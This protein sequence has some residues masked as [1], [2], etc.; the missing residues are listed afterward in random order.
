MGVLKERLST[1][2][3]KHGRESTDLMSRVDAFAKQ[4]KN[5]KKS[6]GQ[7]S[8]HINST[9]KVYFGKNPDQVLAN[10]SASLMKF[11][12]PSSENLYNKVKV[13]P[14]KTYPGQM[15][16]L[17]QSSLPVKVNYKAIDAELE[18]DWYQKPMK[19]KHPIASK[20]S[21]KSTNTKAEETNLTKKPQI[22][23]KLAP[24]KQLDNNKR[25]H[26]L[27][28]QEGGLFDEGIPEESEV[29]ESPDV[30][31]Q[32]INNTRASKLINRP[33]GANTIDIEE[34][35]MD[36]L[37]SDYLEYSQTQP[38]K[39]SMMIKENNTT[40]D[41]NK[42]SKETQSMKT[43]TLPEETVQV[44]QIQEQQNKTLEIEHKQY[45]EKKESLKSLTSMATSKR[46][47]YSSG[48]NEKIEGL[49]EEDNNRG[50]VGKVGKIIPGPVNTE[51]KKQDSMKSLEYEPSES[52]DEQVSYDLT[53]EE[54]Q[55]KDMQKSQ[56]IIVHKSDGCVRSS[57][58]EYSE[59]VN[60]NEEIVEEIL[61]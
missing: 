26:E 33:N 48:I 57:S 35:K 51:K 53:V 25:F 23:L 27:K 36:R 44:L 39:S 38:L 16:K 9:I 32:S 58:Y 54:N 55:I 50:D 47:S 1:Y 8:D 52:K 12:Y 7:F 56:K 14:K 61:E 46:N 59:P 13:N 17:H 41:L 37:E 19:H 10:R 4:Q 24:K 18:G 5:N 43:S 45:S 40:S 29:S 21:A 49:E 31:S 42:E 30:D 34:E 20:V 15:R 2:E 22:G 11:L 60:S 28:I 3:S 6:V